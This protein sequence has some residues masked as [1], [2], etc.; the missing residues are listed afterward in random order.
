MKKHD[1]HVTPPIDKIMPAVDAVR[2]HGGLMVTHTQE[3]QTLYGTPQGDVIHARI[4]KELITL[5]HV[6]PVKSALFEDAQPQLYEA[7]VQ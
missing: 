7:V 6:R 2:K 5:G 3:G 1:R 4:A